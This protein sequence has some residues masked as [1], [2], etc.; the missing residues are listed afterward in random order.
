MLHFGPPLGGSD[1]V[2]PPQPSQNGCGPDPSWAKV[3][4]DCVLPS[5]G[6]WEGR[7]CR[8]GAPRRAGRGTRMRDQGYILE[9][10]KMLVQWT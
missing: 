3:P 5:A 10:Q 9:G 1:A 4:L 6:R 8:L 2:A 7:D